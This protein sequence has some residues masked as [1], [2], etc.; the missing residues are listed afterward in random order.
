MEERSMCSKFIAINVFSRQ[1][2]V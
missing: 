2:P 1:L